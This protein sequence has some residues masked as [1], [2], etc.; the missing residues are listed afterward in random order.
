[1]RTR[2]ASLR[3]HGQ[4]PWRWRGDAGRGRGGGRGIGRIPGGSSVAGATCMMYNLDS[5]ITG[6]QFTSLNLTTA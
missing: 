3:K 6:Q 2:S 4:R 1:M 5:P